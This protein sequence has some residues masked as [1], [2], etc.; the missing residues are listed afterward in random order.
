MRQHGAG[1][2]LPG[3]ACYMGMADGAC[4]GWA[5]P[6]RSEKLCS[7]PPLHLEESCA[8]APLILP[9][10]ISCS[11]RQ[12]LCIQRERAH[13]TSDARRQE[14]EGLRGQLERAQRAAEASRQEAEG[15]RVQLQAGGAARRELLAQLAGAEEGLRGSRQMCSRLLEEGQALRREVGALAGGGRAGRHW[16]GRW[17]PRCCVA[18]W[19][20]AQGRFV[21]AAVPPGAMQPPW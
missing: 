5:G 21:L 2:L 3:W 16:Q 9:H 10:L 20:S 6:C 18:F 17:R 19:G 13:A 4:Q 7:M 8:F 1:S 11:R 12:A 14:A 15:L